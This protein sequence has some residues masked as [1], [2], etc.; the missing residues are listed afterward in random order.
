MFKLSEAG[1]PEDPSYPQDL[2]QLGYEHRIYL[3]ETF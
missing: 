1:M 2:S 3:S